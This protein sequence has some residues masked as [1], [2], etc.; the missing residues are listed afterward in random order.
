MAG[1]SRSR[2]KEGS[3]RSARPRAKQRGSVKAGTKTKAV[4]RMVKRKS[5]GRV[6]VSGEFG[7]TALRVF[8][9]GVYSALR[10]LAVRG[11]PVTIKEKGRLVRGVPTVSPKGEIS[12]GGKSIRA[13]QKLR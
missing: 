11:I 13:A 5:A 9:G 1:K 6:A 4:G 7:E 8:Q 3:A 2:V 10:N 12:I